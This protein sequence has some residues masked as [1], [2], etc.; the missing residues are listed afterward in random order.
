LEKEL[1]RVASQKT[2]FQSIYGFFPKI[3]SENDEEEQSEA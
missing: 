3:A 1:K 2:Y